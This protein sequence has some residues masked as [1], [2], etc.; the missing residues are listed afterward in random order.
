MKDRVVERRCLLKWSLIAAG[1][2]LFGL[3]FASEV[4]I[5]RAY[6]GRPVKLG[7][8]LAAW[9]IC[10][11]LWFGLT[12]FVL[13]LARRFPLERRRWLVNL[14]F[15]LGAS[16]AF[17]LLQLGAYVL[18]ASAVGLDIGKRP[19]FEAYR[20]IFVGDFHFDLLTYWALI[21]L[22]H[23]LDYY[24]KYRERELRA[25]QLETRLAQ[26]ELD[27]L[28]MQLHPHFL[29]NTLNSISVL[30]AEDVKQARRML[31]RLSDLLRASLENKGTHEVTLK[32]EL[33]FLESYLEIEQTRFQDR[34]TV[35]MEVD[36]KALDAR[37]PNLIL[38]P[39]VENAIRHGIAPRAAAG[40][41][42][43]RA[44]RLNGMVQLEVRDNGAGL[45]GARPE[46]LMK[47]IGLSNTRA[48]LE[49]LYGASHRFELQDEDGHGLTVKI[50]IPFSNGAKG[51]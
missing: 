29:F 26:A 25:A 19:F 27:A 16:A 20:T 9:L 39:L 15:H 28:R 51:D 30:M 7:E 35:R 17:A 31:T 37:V 22:S 34:L 21:G 23:A 49:Q 2:T 18:V 4:I 44:Q 11:Y 1:W 48:R 3:F 13:Y 43:I 14:L 5:S 40:L 50:A 32:E 24:R 41:I 33:E 42:E 45:N 47:G 12:P 10:A 36:P 6:D 8:T 38:Q 46:S